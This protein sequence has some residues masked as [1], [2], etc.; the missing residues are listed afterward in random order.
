MLKKV[1][2]EIEDILSKAAGRCVSIHQILSFEPHKLILKGV[3]ISKKTELGMEKKL[4]LPKIVLTF[5]VYKML[6][7]LIL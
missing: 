2:P 5:S 6:K 7:I 3:N 4:Y 1:K